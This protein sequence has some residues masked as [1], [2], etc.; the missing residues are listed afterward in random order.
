MAAR[1]AR[2]TVGPPAPP[3]SPMTD[4]RPRST[5]DRITPELPRAPMSEPLV[6]AAHTSASPSPAASRSSHTET[7]VSDMLV[8]VSPSGTG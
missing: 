2:A 4:T 3:S 6:I 8:P 5:C 7:R 1:S